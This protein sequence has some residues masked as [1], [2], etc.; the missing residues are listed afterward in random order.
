MR[1]LPYLPLLVSAFGLLVAATA[2]VRAGEATPPEPDMKTY[3]LVLVRAAG[4][5]RFMDE[6]AVQATQEAHLAWLKRLHADGKAVAS[7][8]IERGGDLR[9]A[10]VL[11]VASKEEAEAIVRD[12]PW[13][14]AGR[15]APEVHPWWASGGVFRRT[16][17]VTRLTALWLGLLKRPPDAPGLPEEKL[18]ELQ[19]GHMANIRKMAASG[20]LAIAGPTGDDGALRGIFVFRTDD[21]E[22]LRA[23]CAEDPAVKAGRLTVELYRWAVPE[24]A[25]P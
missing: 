4:K 19:N 21:P 3:Q 23:L 16:T 1:R 2:I 9:S 20:D 15:V 11:D 18:K 25:I 13:V 5:P 10:L 7:G 12:D 17:D 8:P 22:H 6:R 24:G 14:K